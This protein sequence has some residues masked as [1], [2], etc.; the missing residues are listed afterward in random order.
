MEPSDTSDPG[1]QEEPNASG[2]YD[3]EA[4]ENG[5]LAGFVVDDDN[6]DE[7]DGRSE[8]HNKPR[9]EVIN[10]TVPEDKTGHISDGQEADTEDC[11]M[12]V[13]PDFT[14]VF[15][16]TPATHLLIRFKGRRPMSNPLGSMS[17][18]MCIA[19]YSL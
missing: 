17:D 4:D 14:Y 11:A 8:D 6:E 16:L 5:N 1:A 2:Y 12:D 19:A 7:D 3:T 9:G 10:D 18:R 15:I 13:D